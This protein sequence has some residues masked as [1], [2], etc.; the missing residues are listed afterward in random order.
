[1]TCP[2]IRKRGGKPKGAAPGQ[3]RTLPARQNTLFR[4]CCWQPL[5][6][7][8]H[9]VHNLLARVG[10]NWAILNTFY[11]L[12]CA[13]TPNCNTK[14]YDNM[15]KLQFFGLFK[16][17]G[18]IS[19][20]TYFDAQNCCTKQFYVRFNSPRCKSRLKKIIWTFVNNGLG[21]FCK[22]SFLSLFF[23]QTF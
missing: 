14:N 22:V 6:V 16:M 7:E 1:M 2:G 21:F 8:N 9:L 12:A 13:A 5:P 15:E 11:M 3:G 18:E 19:F 10:E 4:M 20:Q 17:Y 23:G